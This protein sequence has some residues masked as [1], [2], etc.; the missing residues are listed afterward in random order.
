MIDLSLKWFSWWLNIHFEVDI[1][2]KG[3]AGAA[4]DKP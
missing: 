4:A 2:K 1:V 3:C